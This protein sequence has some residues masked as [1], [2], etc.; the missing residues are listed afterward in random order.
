MNTVCTPVETYPAASGLSYLVHERRVRLGV[1]PG[2]VRVDLPELD[3]EDA[4]GG[5]AADL[6][7]AGRGHPARQHVQRLQNNI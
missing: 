4:D 1:L 7:A 2:A 5:G 6:P 3:G